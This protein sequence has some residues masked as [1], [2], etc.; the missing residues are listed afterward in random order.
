MAKKT[1]DLATAVKRIAT[2]YARG[3]AFE[4]ARGE[5]H[6]L[7]PEAM[8]E[9]LAL[10][11][12]PKAKGRDLLVMALAD[13]GYPP[14]LP[15]M[16]RWLDDADEEKIVCPALTA[17]DRAAGERFGADRVWRTHGL[18]PELRAAISA[19]WDAGAGLPSTDEEPWLTQQ[20]EKR[21]RDAVEVPPPSPE[22]DR[23]EKEA[24]TPDL[25]ALKQAVD[26]LDPKV[27]LR[28]GVAAIRRALPIYERWAKDGAILH[29]ALAATE[30]TLDGS[31][32]DRDREAITAALRRAEKAARFS[33]AHRRYH[34]NA[35]KAAQQVA[36]GVLYASGM[37]QLQPMHYARNA[38]EFSGGG[39][40]AIRTEL[41]WQL[42]QVRAAL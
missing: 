22:L 41:D 9:V 38:I 39:F 13:V 17:L 31:P 4:D 40:A 32:E 37:T 19:W 33:K 30:R 14:A 23:E 34:V 42:E 21:A 27:A 10:A 35:A 25:I 16:R 24:L 3:D 36:Q 26:K 15:A 8:R 12:A 7:P 5:L 6:E 20:I 18:V 1:V 11:T 2:G 29:A 28:L